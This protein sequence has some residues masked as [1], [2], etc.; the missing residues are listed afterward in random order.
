MAQRA[1]DTTWRATGSDVSRMGARLAPMRDQPRG[2]GSRAVPCIVPPVILEQIARRG[3]DVQRERARRAL[4]LDAEHRAARTGSRPGATDAVAGS[5]Q[6]TISTAGGAET[7]P[8]RPV[9]G[10]GDPA[11]GDAAVDEA[12]DWLGATYD[13]YLEAY[14]RHSIDD[15]ELPLPATVHY[16]VD[17]DNAF[18]DGTRMVF[19]DGD[20]DLFNRFT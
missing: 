16:G 13:F 19:G 15:R 11:T 1:P 14:D 20:G 12:Y 5:P 3:D 17:Y 10:E 8:G 2:S 9:R 7:L 6:R 4:A 18:W